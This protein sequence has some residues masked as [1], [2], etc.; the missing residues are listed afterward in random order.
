MYTLNWLRSQNL[1]LKLHCGWVGIG[2]VYERTVH[3]QMRAVLAVLAVFA[4]LAAL[5]AAPACCTCSPA[6]VSVQW[7]YWAAGE[8]MA[9]SCQQHYRKPSSDLQ[10]RRL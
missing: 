8:K 1:L 7:T 3:V 9:L 6:A 4:V 2:T 10:R 5:A